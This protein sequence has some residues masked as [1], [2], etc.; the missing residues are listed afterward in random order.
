MFSPTGTLS[1]GNTS[2]CCCRYFKSL[3]GEESHQC[4]SIQ[5]HDW[6]YFGCSQDAWTEHD[7][8]CIIKYKAWNNVQHACPSPCPEAS[9]A[10]TN[11]EGSSLKKLCKRKCLTC[12]QHLTSLTGCFVTSAGQKTHLMHCTGSR[13]AVECR[14]ST[15][16]W[17]RGP[18]ALPQ[19]AF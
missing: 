19:E 10:N 2:T 18:S 12:F 14:D 1:K 13:C 8:C 4:I 9:P 6:M 15:A 7:V 17:Q 11:L 3:Q 5:G 16:T